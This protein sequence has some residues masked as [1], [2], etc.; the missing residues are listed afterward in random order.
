[1][2]TL[3]KLPWTHLESVYRETSTAQFVALLIGSCNDRG[4]LLR[5]ATF[6]RIEVGY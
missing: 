3:G 6:V 5:N 4:G 2:V 1:M